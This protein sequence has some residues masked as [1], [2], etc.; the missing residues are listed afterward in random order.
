[1]RT[2]QPSPFNGLNLLDGVTRR[3]QRAI[4]HLGTS[5]DF[6]AGTTLK[7]GAL[8]CGQHIVVLRGVV[9]FARDGVTRA[10]LHGGDSWGEG[11]RFPTDAGLT[12]TTVMP[13]RIHVYDDREM[14]A[15]HQAC[16][17]LAQRLLRTGANR[18]GGR[19]AEIVPPKVPVRASLKRVSA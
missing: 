3:Q 2:S 4:A 14:A 12:A 9:A 1:M 19:P 15:L 6:A 13:T 5:L 16:P 10:L 18:G 11:G 8:S 7:P 17:L